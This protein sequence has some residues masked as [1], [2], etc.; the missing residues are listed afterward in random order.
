M[1]AWLF[2]VRLLLAE[3]EPTG[4]IVVRFSGLRND[5][6]K[7]VAAVYNRAEGFPTDPSKVLQGKT[8]AIS[9]KTAQIVFDNLPYG[10]YAVV[11]IHDENEN[12]NLDVN[13]LGI[14]VE[15]YGA[16]NNPRFFFGPP[17]FEEA[18]FRLDAPE[19]VVVLQ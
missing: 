15:G 14:P 9:G 4:K 5:K 6:G 10:N 7:V 16:S 19:K 18:A 1:T 8:G 17:K 2:A 3:P 11:F 13:F 12:R